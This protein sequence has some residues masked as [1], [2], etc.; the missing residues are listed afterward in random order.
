MPRLRCSG[1]WEQG[2]YGRQPM[3]ELVLQFAE[4]KLTGGGVDVVG[5]FTFEGEIT[6]QQIY[7]LK[8]Y[9]GLHQ[10]QYHGVCD[11]EGLYCG[12]WSFSGFPGG[13][14]LI[15]VESLDGASEHQQAEFV[16]IGP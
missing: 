4:R 2:S 15:R 1:W 14:W 6:G 16:E 11:G 12:Y 10:I 8:Q 5:R 7:L 9:I 3:H 13:K